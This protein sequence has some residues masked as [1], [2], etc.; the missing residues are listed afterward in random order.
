MEKTFAKTNRENPQCLQGWDE[1][2]QSE[3]KWAKSA[4]L[5]FESGAFNHSATLPYFVSAKYFARL[6]ACGKL[7][8][9]RPIRAPCG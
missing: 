6:H 2:F 9:S 1:V 5:G 4:F 7:I 3:K 8:L